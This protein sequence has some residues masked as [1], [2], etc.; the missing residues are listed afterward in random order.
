M[1]MWVFILN[2]NTDLNNDKYAFQNKGISQ[3]NSHMC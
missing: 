2:F 3:S 1:S